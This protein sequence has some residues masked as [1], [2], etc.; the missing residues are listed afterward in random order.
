[1]D[2]SVREKMG[3]GKPKLRFQVD[4]ETYKPAK[5]GNSTAEQDGS[6]ILLNDKN[7]GFMVN[8]AIVEFWSSCD[9]TKTVNQLTDQFAS[10]LGM[11]REQV[12]QEVVQL[13]QQLLESELLKP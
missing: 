4:Y 2:P 3:F 1:M 6:L 9:G 11:P 8:Q 10:K 5:T 12:E 13:I 7:Q